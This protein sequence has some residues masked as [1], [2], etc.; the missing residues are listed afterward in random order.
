[1]TRSRWEVIGTTVAVG[2]VSALNP[3]LAAV[4]PGL[5]TL[6]K[7]ELPL[8]ESELDAPGREVAYIV[9]ARENFG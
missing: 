2:L 8:L 5:F 9:H 4:V 6:L 7:G 3:A 1:M